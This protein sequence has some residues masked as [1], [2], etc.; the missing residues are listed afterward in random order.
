M[1]R[2][3]LKVGKGQLTFEG[4]TLSEACKFGAIAGMIPEVCDACSS[5]NIYL[6][7]KAP[8]GNDYYT[9]TCRDCGAELTMHQ[10]KDGGFYIKF[11]EKMSVYTK[12]QNDATGEKKAE[13]VKNPED[14]KPTAAG[15]DVSF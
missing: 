9:V 1:I 8:K 12:E 13:Q 6:S 4:Q 7:H 2:Y 5:I 11:G 10:R 15:T 14:M 3:T